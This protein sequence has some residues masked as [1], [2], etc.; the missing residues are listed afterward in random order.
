MTCNFFLDLPPPSAKCDHGQLGK[1]VGKIGKSYW[2]ICQSFFEFWHIIGF[3]V[4]FVARMGPLRMG[5]RKVPKI[6]QK[7][8]RQ[9][10]YIG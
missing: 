3:F 2:M 4:S 7:N 9:K 6:H 1:M 5:D 10:K 8:L